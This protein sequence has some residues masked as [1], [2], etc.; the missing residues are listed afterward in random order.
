MA[1]WHDSYLGVVTGL[2]NDGYECQ[3][4]CHMIGFIS[5]ECPQVTRE[6]GNTKEAGQSPMLGHYPQTPHWSRDKWR[7]LQVSH[8]GRDLA[9]SGHRSFSNMISMSICADTN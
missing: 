4:N 7:L 6:S 9:R 8:D 5:Y 1:V 2:Y 3:T